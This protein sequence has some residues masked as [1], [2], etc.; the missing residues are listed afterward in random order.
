MCVRTAVWARE[1]VSG[2]SYVRIPAFGRVWV[3]G[4]V[5]SVAPAEKG[6]ERAR[7]TTQPRGL[8]A[9]R[10]HVQ[11]CV[12]FVYAS[13]CSFLYV[14]WVCVCVHVCMNFFAG[15]QQTE[16]VFQ[17]YHVLQLKTCFLC[18]DTVFWILTIIICSIYTFSY[19]IHRRCISSAIISSGFIFI[20]IFALHVIIILFSPMFLITFINS[21]KGLY[22]TNIWL[23]SSCIYRSVSV[24]LLY[25]VMSSNSLSI[26]TA[27]FVQ[28]QDWTWHAGAFYCT[29]ACVD[30]CLRY[31]WISARSHGKIVILHNLNACGISYHLTHVCRTDAIWRLRVCWTPRTSCGRGQTPRRPLSSDTTLSRSPRPAFMTLLGIISLK[32]SIMRRNRWVLWA[33]A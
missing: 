2:C 28:Q 7:G 30:V 26:C 27:G 5:C 16:I 22:R 32:T 25:L 1:R 29:S 20:I 31:L 24:Y 19:S 9:K 8:E 13:V 33:T 17:T 10:V 14:V 12:L 21:T 23:I 6:N 4:C 11:R 3:G 15:T 18:R